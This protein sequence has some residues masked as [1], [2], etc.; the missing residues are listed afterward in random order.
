[1]KN[2]LL[3]LFL[4]GSLN[5]CFAQKKW[6]KIDL[7]ETFYNYENKKTCWVKSKEPL[8]GKFA[9]KMNPH[10]VNKEQFMD[11]L[12]HGETKIYRN[13]KLAE[14]GFYINNLR[15]NERFYYNK[16]GSI[17]K[18][19][20][21]KNGVR[22]ST[23][24]IYYKG[25]ISETYT[26]KNNHLNGWASQFSSTKPYELIEKAFY[27]D[28]KKVKKIRFQT[29]DD[30]EF[31]VSDS[32]FY[33]E[34]DNLKL[35]KTYINDSLYL[36]IEI[37]KNVIINDIY[38]RKTTKINIYRANKLDEIF[39]FP[40][41]DFLETATRIL[42]LLN[43]RFVFYTDTQKPHLLLETP[44]KTS[45]DKTRF[46][47]EYPLGNLQSVIYEYE[48]DPRSGWYYWDVDR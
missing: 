44:E 13:K 10:Q 39:Y 42:N 1:M 47:I 33:D 12:K 17:R 43:Y 32:L 34:K 25:K 7:E 14:K 35:Q 11:G 19:S 38:N 48:N 4:F 23:E 45:F 21:Y 2:I 30:L 29:V 9:I 16:N 22:D 8:T 18:I 5:L 41:K 36:Q 46:Y 37:N 3:F 28:D 20:N 6:V 15:E 26:Y 27:V 24:T 40:D 31:V